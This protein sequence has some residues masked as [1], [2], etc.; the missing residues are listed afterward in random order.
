MDRSHT[1]QSEPPLLSPPRSECQSWSGEECERQ[2]GSDQELHATPDCADVESAEEN[3]AVKKRTTTADK[4]LKKTLNVKK[5]PR[6]KRV[7]FSDTETHIPGRR[8]RYT[9]KEES[10]TTFIVFGILSML[11]LSIYLFKV[12]YVK[13]V[14]TAPEKV[15][16]MQHI[17]RDMIRQ[18][19][20]LR[21]ITSQKKTFW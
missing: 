12:Y 9:K 10:R 3:S 21:Q 17:Q 13:E 18:L 4:S 7:S 8:P 5:S 19:D 11:L 1:A 16:S 2:S 14:E 6:P 15:K 20:L